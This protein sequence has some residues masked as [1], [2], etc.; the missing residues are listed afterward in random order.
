M[1]PLD[2]ETS[3]FWENFGPHNPS[4]PASIQ[5]E[6]F[7]LPTTCFA[8]EDGALVNSARWLQWHWK[9][10]Q[11]PGEAQIRHLDHGRALPPAA[12]DVPQGRRRIPRPAP[13]P[14]LGLHQSGRTQPGGTGQGNER[15]GARRSQGRDRRRR[16]LQA[17]PAARRLRPIA[18][19]R[20][21]H[22]AAAGSSRAA[23][24]RRATRWRAAT[25]RDPR[26]Q[27][28]APNWAWAWPAN[29]RILYNRAGADP[30][31]KPWNPGEADHRVERQ[32][33]GSASTC[34]TMGRPRSPPRRRARSS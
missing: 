26:E 20:H 22:V 5:T 25:R 8:E 15:P 32:P 6:V 18:R 19:R 28:I 3:R 9:A 23:T 11:P 34:R 4:D 17:G 2:T 24:P 27:G 13:Q 30:S 14:D 7:Q 31:G 29:R 21:D 10:A 1:D 33:S 12:R 16:S